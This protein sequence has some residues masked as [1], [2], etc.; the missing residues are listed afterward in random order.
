MG[1]RGTPSSSR[2]GDEMGVERENV[3]HTEEGNECDGLGEHPGNASEDGEGVVR[4]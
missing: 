1:C 2:R 3:G 4:E